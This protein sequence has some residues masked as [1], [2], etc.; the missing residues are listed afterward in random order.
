MEFKYKAIDQAGLEILDVIASANRFNKWM[1]ET[2]SPFCAGNILEIG[3]GLGNISQYF[4]KD[5]RSVFL[6]DIRPNYLNFCKEAFN[7][8]NEKIL[9]ID[10]ADIDFNN[11]YSQLL[12]RFD[13]VFCLNVLE[14]IKDDRLAIENMANL[15]KDNGRLTV[16]V[17]AHQF[18]YNGIDAALQH[19]K[20]YNKKIFKQLVLKRENTTILFYFNATGILSCFIGGNLFKNDTI[21]KNKM[22]LYDLLVPIWK[23]AD[24]LTF[25]KIG[26]SLV[27]VI[28]KNHLP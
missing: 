23:I 28:K 20:R 17:P 21:P 4:I 12:G 9:N 19:Y 25:S 15:L 8:D 11:S 3:C 26:L 27:C 2:I 16:L 13:S 5:N 14:H 24:M 7:L 6:S 18:L 1:Y 10:I 22:K